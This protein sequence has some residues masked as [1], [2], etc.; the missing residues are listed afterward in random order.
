M[1]FLLVGRASRP[2]QYGFR[3]TP[4]RRQGR[5]E[6]LQ[7]DRGLTQ[8]ERAAS[9]DVYLCHYLTNA[10]ASL[11]TPDSFGLL[12]HSVLSFLACGR[13]PTLFLPNES[14][15]EVAILDLL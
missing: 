1:A 4:Q 2:L 12:S 15:C 11:R 13:L 7:E 5:K 6:G 14:H 8:A 10:Q 9:T 3:S